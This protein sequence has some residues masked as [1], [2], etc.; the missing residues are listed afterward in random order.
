[1]TNRA[2]PPTAMQTRFGFISRPTPSGSQQY[3]ESTLASRS[4]SISPSSTVSAHSSSSASVASQRLSKATSKPPAN[5]SLI[6]STAASN[7]PRSKKITSPRVRDT[8]VS[9]STVHS[10][11]AA[12]QMRSRTPSRTSSATALPTS[13]VAS[14]PP[15]SSVPTSSS[16]NTTTISKTDV[17][18]IRDRYRTQKRMNFFSRHT[19]VSA[20]NGSPVASSFKSSPSSMTNTEKQQSTPKLPSP[21]NSVKLSKQIFSFQKK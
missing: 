18:A 4:R 5:Q 9:K 8:S 11:T 13:S 3:R 2:P 1:M 10:P 20:A 14:P 17:N 12:S 15:P 21:K 16:S 19:P 7:S 6:S